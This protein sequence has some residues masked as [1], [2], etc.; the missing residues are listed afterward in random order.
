MSP[1]REKS[2]KSAAGIGIGTYDLAICVDVIRLRQGGPC[3]RNVKAKALRLRAGKAVPGGIE[4]G[5]PP[6]DQV[7]TGVDAEDGG[8][9]SAGKIELRKST[10]FPREAMLY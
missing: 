4:P 9:D 8:I 3:E 1:D 5:I 7:T 10:F 6:A 2:M